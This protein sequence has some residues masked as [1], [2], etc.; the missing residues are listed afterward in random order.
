MFEKEEG[1]VNSCCFSND[2]SQV[3][4]SCDW[5]NCTNP[6]CTSVSHCSWN[7][8]AGMKQILPF[9][10]T[11]VANCKGLPIL[12][13]TIWLE[14]LSSGADD[15]FI[16]QD[17]V[18]HGSIPAEDLSEPKTIHDLNREIL[19]KVAHQTA[20]LNFIISGNHREQNKRFLIPA[21]SSGVLHSPWEPPVSLRATCHNLQFDWL[22]RRL[23]IRIVSY[24]TNCPCS[25]LSPSLVNPDPLLVA[26]D[27]SIVPA[28]Y[29]I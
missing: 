16:K 22:D 6:S 7:H 20:P 15:N 18:M 12:Q 25:A 21:S 14:K 28:K 24:H 4:W 13:T 1:Q 17:L 8:A 11:Q 27:L 9:W 23:T 10:E 3:K 26:P 5:P 19:A 2:P 29:H